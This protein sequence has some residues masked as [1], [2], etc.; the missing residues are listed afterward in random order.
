MPMPQAA[1]EY[2]GWWRTSVAHGNALEAMTHY[3]N[4]VGHSRNILAQITPTPAIDL[5]LGRA[6]KASQ[7]YFL[8][9]RD[10]TA[11][12][13]NAEA[14]A[15]MEALAQT[16]EEAKPSEMATALGLG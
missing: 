5:A 10:V 3:N 4:V 2:L 12:P 13:P 7:G 9:Q 8:A 6:I 14:L 1:A 15:A 16:L 11:R